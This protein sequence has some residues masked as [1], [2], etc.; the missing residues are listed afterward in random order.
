[1]TMQLAPE[2][3]PATSCCGVADAGRLE[4]AD[5]AASAAIRGPVK[6]GP[7]LASEAARLTR[8]LRGTRSFTRSLGAYLG[9]P[10][11]RQPRLEDCRRPV[12]TSD[13]VFLDVDPGDPA[14]YR[15]GWL[16]P[17]IAGPAF[18]AAAIS[19][20]VIEHRL[21]FTL[22]QR[23]ALRAG[24]IPLGE[25]LEDAERSNHFAYTIAT[26]PQADFPVIH[27]QATLLLGGVPVA[28]VRETVLWRVLT[29]RNHD[30]TAAAS[31]T[32]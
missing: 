21:P 12:S 32:A 28:L 8:G 20:L 7:T 10:L 14:L 1:M 23:E 22:E 6:A 2:L 24:E 4:L 16:V 30:R 27:V 11:R 31:T 5:A 3:S 13:A 19:A 26:R 29:H 9:T 18:Y 25:L 17:R 15:E